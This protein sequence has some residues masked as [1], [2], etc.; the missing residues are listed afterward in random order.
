MRS[1]RLVAIVAVILMLGF[2]LPSLCFAIVASD[3]T[4]SEATMPG[5]CHGQQEPMPMP[6]HSCCYAS[7]QV[8]QGVPIASAPV[9]QAGTA[10]FIEM[11]GVREMRSEVAAAV[12][13]LDS[14]PPLPAVL[15]I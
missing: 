6:S 14:S 2:T 4:T 11:P 13:P 1:S 15:R 8:P 10:E 9:P 7:H 5:A 12:A 3:V